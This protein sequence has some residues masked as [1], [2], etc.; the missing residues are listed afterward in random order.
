MTRAV[1]SPLLAVVPP[2]PVF[3]VGTPDG[4]PLGLLKAAVVA[5]L[6]SGD[7]RLVVDL[8]PAG[9][10]AARDVGTLLYAQALC[11]QAGGSLSLRLTD[12]Q[13]ATLAPYPSLLAE[14]PVR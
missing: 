12:D 6:G 11:D 5:Q 9:A 10:L 4:L 7:A 8:R 1:S 13:R 2:P 3:E 14:E